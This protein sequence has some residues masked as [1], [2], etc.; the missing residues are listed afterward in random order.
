MTLE[1]TNKAVVRRYIEEVINQNKV[2]VIDE[3]FAP[4]M[5]GRFGHTC[6]LEDLFQM[7]MKRSRILLQKAILLWCAGISKRLTWEHILKSR[8]LGS[9]LR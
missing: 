3:L 7:R 2:E 9:Q 1:E 5:R 4:E 6:L 8:Q